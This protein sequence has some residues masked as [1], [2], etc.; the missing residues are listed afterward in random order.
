MILRKTKAITR[1]PFAVL[2]IGSSKICCMIGEADGS[3]GCVF[4][5]MAHM[6]HQASELAK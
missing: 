2:D 3:G 4:L 6:R 5:G 1:R